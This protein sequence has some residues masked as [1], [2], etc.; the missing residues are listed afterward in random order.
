[1]LGGEVEVPT[2]K[3]TRV[4]LTIPA[5]TQNGRVFRLKGQGMPR[6]KEA[7]QHGDLLAMVKVTLPTKLSEAEQEL[8]R[9]LR[10]ARAG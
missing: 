3:G 4:A 10:E 5:E 7:S 9:R 8:F 2:I 1:M 6:Q